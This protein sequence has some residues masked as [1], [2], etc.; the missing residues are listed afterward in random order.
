[1]EIRPI[2]SALLRNRTGAILVALQIA[3]TLAVVTNALFIINQRLEKIGRPSG[4]DTDNI[5]WVQ[6]YGYRPDYNH[7]VTID[8]DLALIRATPGVVAASAIRGIPLSGGGSSTSYKVSPEKSSPDVPGNYY[9]GDEQALDALGVKLVAGRR[10]SKDIIRY[11][12]KPSS[13]MVPEIIVTRDM[14]KA[15]FNTDE[16]VG[17]QVYDNLGQSATVVGV[18]DRMLGAWVDWDKLSQVVFHPLVESGPFVR[19]AVRAQP[20]RRDALIA[21]LEKKLT[22]SNPTRVIS[23]VRPHDYYIER[24]YKPDRRMAVLL[25]VAIGLLVTMTTLGIVGLAS[26]TVN[27]RVKQIGT[28]RAVGARKVDILRYFMVENWILTT[29]G[30]AAGCILAYVLSYWLS[31]AYSLPMLKLSYLLI[32]VPCMWILGQL[33]VLVPARRGA[34]VAPAVATRTV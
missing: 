10:F 31:T 15:L 21:E 19:Y 8:E 2:I 23:W 6:S 9:E 4:M 17:K 34:A 7:R 12:D 20:G 25:T 27:A 14:A 16:V 1:M 13:K 32:A 3:I 18:I 24:S 28:R 22:E 11:E 33:A 26:F 29:A 30:L 5:L